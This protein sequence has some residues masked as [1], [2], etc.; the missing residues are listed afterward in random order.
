MKRVP[1]LGVKAPICDS[2]KNPKDRRGVNCVFKEDIEKAINLLKPLKAE[3]K[4]RAVRK[5]CE[6]SE[7]S[8]R[9]HEQDVVDFVKG[10]F[11]IQVSSGNFSF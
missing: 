9:M 8:N 7:I 1:I 6:S 2:V 5:Y 10:K 4:D 11:K 3:L